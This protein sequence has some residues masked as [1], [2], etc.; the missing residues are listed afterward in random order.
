MKLKEIKTKIALNI[1]GEHFSLDIPFSQQDFVRKIEA[2][3]RFKLQEYREKFPSRGQ[4]EHLVMM[5]YHFATSYFSLQRQHEEEIAE[6]E[7]LLREATRL[8]GADRLDPE[9][10]GYDEPDYE[11]S[12]E[13]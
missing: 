4:K 8:C 6:A 5:A 12:E 1:G 13:Y 9:D 7:D 11:E 10:S 2:E 3:M